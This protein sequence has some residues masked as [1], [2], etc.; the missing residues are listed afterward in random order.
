MSAF[1]ECR[2]CFV[3]L[4]L[5]TEQLSSIINVFEYSKLLF[6]EPA[7]QNIYNAPSLSILYL[8]SQSAER[9]ILY[10]LLISLSLSTCSTSEVFTS[11]SCFRI[12]FGASP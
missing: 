5:C 8:S 4:L 3:D 6:F 9:E 2:A 10:L 7:I 12:A 11:S 1:S